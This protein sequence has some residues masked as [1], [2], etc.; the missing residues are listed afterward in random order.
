MKEKIKKKKILA[1]I[2]ARKGSKEIPSKNKKILSGKPLISW[3]VDSAL[4]SSYINKIVVSTDDKEII[5]LVSNK[6]IETPFLRPK[7][8]SGDHSSTE[9]VLLH[10]LEFLEKNEEYVPDIVILLQPTSPLRKEGSIDDAIETFF[11]KKSDSLLSV[12]DS[13]IFF[14]KGSPPK[15]NYDYFKRPMRQDVKRENR[16][17]VENGSIYITKTSSLINKRN[18]ISGKISLFE[19]SQE[20]SYEIDTYL[21]WTILDTILKKYGYEN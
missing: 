4:S 5:D 6:R 19:M 7:K 17:F 18:R 9:S 12:T 1:I 20:E 11:K 21:D 16:I 8:F 2:P 3:T 10:C 14:W 15:A 13:K